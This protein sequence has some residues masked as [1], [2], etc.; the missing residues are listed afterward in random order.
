MSRDPVRN[1]FIHLAYIMA[2][3]KHLIS[4]FNVECNKTSSDLSNIV[5]ENCRNELP[6]YSTIKECTK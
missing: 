1:L 6:K 4:Y 5:I 2:Y 3:V